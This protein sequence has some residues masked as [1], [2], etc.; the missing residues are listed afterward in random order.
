MRESRGVSGRGVGGVGEVGVR[1]E[2]N[3][4]HCSPL[5]ATRRPGL[6]V[7]VPVRLAG[8][9]G[10]EADESEHTPNTA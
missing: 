7:C 3:S 2:G 1:G 10:P 5:V 4:S 9:G 8:G 6:P